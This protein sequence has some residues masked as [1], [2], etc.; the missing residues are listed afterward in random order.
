[1]ASFAQMWVTLTFESGEPG[2]Y[3]AGYI[4]AYTIMLGDLDSDSLQKHPL[5]TMIFV[6]Y[7]FGVTIV[8]L[9]ILIAIVSDSYQNSYVSSKMMLGKARIIFVAEISSLKGYHFHWRKGGASD[10]LLSRRNINYFFGTVSMLQIWM[11]TKTINR[12]LSQFESCEMSAS[13]SNRIHLEAIVLF[14]CLA[15]TMA[16]MKMIVAYVLNEFNDTGKLRDPNKPISSTHKAVNL[17][18][19]TMFS[20]L[21]STFDSLFDRSDNDILEGFNMESTGTQEQRSEQ[22]I[23]RSIEKSKKQLK[24][25]LKGMFEQI[26]YSLK[27]QDEQNKRELVSL[28][29]RITNAL[30][31]AIVESHQ[32]LLDS[33]QADPERSI[34]CDDVND[35]ESSS[36]ISLGFDDAT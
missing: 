3:L 25:E 17:F 33:L 28:E 9:N 32:S 24:H 13:S 14:I 29:E 23:Q 20:Y 1:M 6:L 30:A 12:K 22:N 18:I 10:G 27:E 35:E 31:A 7:T 34:S 15:F 26:Q 5:I 19:E 16:G 2:S 8:L 11:V 4:T 36:S 21:S